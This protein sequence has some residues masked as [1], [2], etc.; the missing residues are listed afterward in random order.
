MTSSTNT[1]PTPQN[2]LRD[3]SA[4][5]GLLSRLNHWI[6]AAAF[7]GALGLGLTMAY[8][9]LAREEVSAL[10]DWHKLLGIA[11]LLYGIWRVGWR[12]AE[13]FPAAEKSMPLWQART[14]KAVH[15]GLL[16]AIVAMPLSGVLMTVAGGRAL[17][18]WDVSLLPSFGEIAWLDAAASAI[19]AY[20]P[21]AVLV[22][23]ALHI[24][25]ALKHHFV[26]RDTTLARMTTGRI[27]PE[28]S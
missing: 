10:M 3:G 17:D 27:A 21:W 14:S 9:G 4:T 1:H 16:A 12:I 23:L 24:G 20:A 25:G 18:V 7:L 22:M 13:G 6:T 15:I 26:D 11:V 19:H 2:I 8:G 28:A 5:Y